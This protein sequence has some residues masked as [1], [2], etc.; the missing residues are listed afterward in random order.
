MALAWVIEDTE[1]GAGDER[2]DDTPA[3]ALRRFGDGFFSRDY[4]PLAAPSSV[5]SAS[6]ASSP[7]PASIRDPLLRE[8]NGPTDDGSFFFSSWSSILFFG[9]LERRP[10]QL[11]VGEAGTSGKKREDGQEIVFR[12]EGASRNELF[13]SS[14]CSFTFFR[15]LWIEAWQSVWVFSNSC[16]QVVC[17]ALSEFFRSPLS[18]TGDEVEGSGG[19]DDGSGGREKRQQR[20]IWRCFMMPEGKGL[21]TADEE[22]FP[23]GLCVFKEFT[24]K[25]FRDNATT[26]TPPLDS[27]PVFFLLQSDGMLGF[28]AQHSKSVSMCLRVRGLFFWNTF[29]LIR[30][31]ISLV[32]FC[33]YHCRCTCILT[34]IASRVPCV[35]VARLLLPPP[36]PL[37]RAQMEKRSRVDRWA[38]S[39]G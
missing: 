36:P 15:F 16:T 12:V 21:E 9:V 8:D 27:P 19:R 28:L 4:P 32:V 37:P 26:D 7:S 18:S 38:D 30:S 23:Q 35:S 39:S 33:L 14:V 20:H 13:L 10:G 34:R 2:E 11:S 3:E 31:D 17:F 22:A 5:G 25:I 6:P 1:L 29:L 24:E